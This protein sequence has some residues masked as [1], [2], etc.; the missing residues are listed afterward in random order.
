MFARKVQS[1]RSILLLAFLLVAAHASAESFSHR[2]GAEHFEATV[3]GDRLV[4]KE[5]YQ[6]ATT[7]YGDLSC[8][9]GSAVRA[10]ILPAADARLCFAFAADQ[11]EYTR[12]QNGSPIHTEELATARVPRMCIALSSLD[13]A[14]RLVTLV[15]L[16][17]QPPRTA[18][19]D[20]YGR[21]E[22]ERS[23]SPACKP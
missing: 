2:H 19:S 18:A 10:T 21:A 8:P 15:N 13:E 12:F 1:S 23:L 17:P 4:V 3:A 16:G 20:R 6:G 5:R 14:H 11:C 22:V 7:I 9:L